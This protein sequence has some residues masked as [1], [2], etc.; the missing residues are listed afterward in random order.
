MR[1]LFYFGH[2]A[3]Y[4]FFR[5]V[6]RLLRQQGHETVLAAKKKDVLTGLLE[7]DGEAF[8]N[9]L[10]EGRENTR[11]GILRGLWLREK[12]LFALVREVH[13]DLL[14]GSDPSLV[15]VG[16]LT[17]TPAITVTEDDWRV[18][19]ALAWLA[20]PFTRAILA[21]EACD[22]GPWRYKQVR[23]RGYMKLSYLHPDIFTPDPARVTVQ[24]PFVLVRLASLTAHHDFGATGLTA[25]LTEELVRLCRA[26]GRTVV[27]SSEGPADPRFDGMRPAITPSD[28]HHWLAAA[29]L[30]VS[31]SQSMSVEAAMLG[32]PSVRFSGFAGRISVLE[33]LEHRYR[34]TFG[35]DTRDPG[36]MLRLAGELLATPGLKEEFARRRDAMLRERIRVDRFVAWYLAHF[37]VSRTV[38][39]ENPRMQ[40]PLTTGNAPP[41]DF[42]VLPLTG[43]RFDFTAGTLRHLLYA[44]ANNGR[45]IVPFTEFLEDPGRPAVI[46]RHDVDARKLNA[47]GFARFEHALGVRGTFY[48]RVVPQSYDPQVVDAIAAMGHEIGYHYE[49]MHLAY[50][51]L[52][53]SGVPR[54]KI[55]PEDLYARALELFERHL[56][57]LRR[58]APVTTICMHGSPLS[59][60]DNRDLWKQYDY[61]DFGIAGEPYFNTDFS[62]V[63]YFTDT[64]RMWGGARYAV[65]DKVSWSVGQGIGWSGGQL[66]GSTPDQM[67][68]LPAGKLITADLVEALNDG[69]FPETAMITLHPQRWTGNPAAWLAELVLQRVK[70][71]VKKGLLVNRILLFLLL[72]TSAYGRAQQP[73]TP[74]ARLAAAGF[75]H[76]RAVQRGD[77][78]YV[79]VENR[80]WRWQPRGAAEA[81]HV[82]AASPGTAKVVSLTLLRQGIPVTTLAA[83]LE[84]GDSTG[85]TVVKAVLSDSAWRRV[86]RREPSL[87]RAYNKADV[88]VAPWFLAQFGNYDDPLQAQFNIVP[89]VQVTFL[90][91]LTATAQVVFPLYNNLPGDPDG[92]TIRPGLMTLA[93]TAR[94]PFTTFGSLTAG[95]FTRDR[96][97]VS[98]ELRKYWFNGRLWAGAALGWTGEMRLT[99]G[100]FTYSPIDRFTW[101]CDAAWRFARY[102]LTLQ[103]AYGG[104]IAGDQ[105]WRADV[106]RQFGE[107]EIGFFAMESGGVLN[108]GF[109]FRV[110]LPPRRYGTK[111]AIRLR[112]ASYVPWEYR[113]RGL[114][115][116]GR[117]FSTGSGP[118][119]LLED[120]APDYVRKNAVIDD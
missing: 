85:F 88:S 27:I 25:G 99:E 56:A 55:T 114:P 97:G 62:R 95:Y 106:S 16:R 36:R 12:R 35:V 71:A 40:F 38:M 61:R 14:A 32:T 11:Q 57:M 7:H 66:G 67:T 103:A 82:L 89:T 48:F 92:N 41:D 111:N 64:G 19:P 10:P 33:E 24:H 42:P 60:I 104:F 101:R 49:D 96:Y 65:R 44:I 8:C 74:A 15:H 53:R 72:L 117:S 91:G 30:L 6:I 26:A 100:Y 75:E 34:L 59:P 109:N 80:A 9:L 63:A 94:L 23:Y 4:L 28:M 118:A 5:P 51:E 58:H 110:P 98:G 70:N 78:L 86:L 115:P 120:M 17:G 113:A 83:H 18:I 20:Y 73:E 37:P 76:V 45:R 116:Q 68:R 79:S 105:G 39:R 52:R 43:K 50:R 2:P 21:P 107:V 81:L 13:P 3:Q 47:L 29:D 1:F 77:T 90:R 54:A 46:L 22:T 93:Y 31:D 84:Q 69:T 108:G 87:N 119:V 102:D 112:P